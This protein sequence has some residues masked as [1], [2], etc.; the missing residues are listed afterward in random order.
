MDYMANLAIATSGDIYALDY[1]HNRIVILNPDGTSKTK[2]DNG[3]VIIPPAVEG[4]TYPGIND[5]ANIND[6]VTLSQD[7]SA[8]RVV[9]GPS[10]SLDLTSHTLNISHWWNL[11]NDG[12]SVNFFA[13]GTDAVTDA[14]ISA[15]T[16]TLV[17]D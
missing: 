4:S 5:T 10:S 9:I 7:Q 16:T 14:S 13:S 8:D 3:T 17:G 15:G 2:I 1:F 11:V 12:G 6:S